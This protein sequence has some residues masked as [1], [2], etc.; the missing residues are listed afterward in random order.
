M[1]TMRSP[2]RASLFDWRSGAA[3]KKTA[4]SCKI[5]FARA[6]SRFS[7]RNAWIWA[8]SSSTEPGW[9]AGRALAG[10]VCFTQL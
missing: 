5:A 6:S 4:A 10:A 7:F 3:P 9:A 1:M 2:E 8:R